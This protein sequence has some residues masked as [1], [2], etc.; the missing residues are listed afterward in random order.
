MMKAKFEYQKIVQGYYS[1]GWEDLCASLSIKESRND[2]KAYRVNSPGVYR[3][4][5]RRV[6]IN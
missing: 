6:P 2:L 5:T 4:I 1:Y 3:I